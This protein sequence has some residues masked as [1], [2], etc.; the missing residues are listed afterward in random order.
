M[1]TVCGVL[2]E[3]GEWA[4]DAWGWPD[5][6]FVLNLANMAATYQKIT[7]LVTENQQRFML[8]NKMSQLWGEFAVNL[9]LFLLFLSALLGGVRASP[10]PH[11]C[12]GPT[13][14]W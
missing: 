14:F 10:V 13:F 2:E 12:F 5:L 8:R 4:C 3:A 6:L 9:L 7:T 1:K 11:F